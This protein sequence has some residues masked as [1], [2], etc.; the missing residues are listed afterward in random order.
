MTDTCQGLR[1]EL[2]S[3]KK[4]SKEQRLAWYFE[5]LKL[6]SRQQL[7]SREVRDALGLT[8]LDSREY[9]I[10]REK[11]VSMPSPEKRKRIVREAVKPLLKEAGFR[12]KGQEWWKEL[13]DGWL[14]IHLKSSQFNSPSTGCSFEFDISASSFEEIRGEL[15]KQWI[16]NQC[17]D[18][19]HCCFLPYAGMLS[20][21]CEA[22]AYKIDGYQNYLPKD[23]PLDAILEQVHSD[24]ADYILPQLEK[25]HSISQ[26]KNL[27]EE[28]QAY[29]QEREII[30]L[31]FYHNVCGGVSMG[32]KTSLMEWYQ[33][34]YSLTPE[35]VL[36]HLDWLETIC[37]YSSWP[38]E[39]R[40][41]EVRDI[42]QSLHTKGQE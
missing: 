27:Y 6:P 13:E 10:Q 33:K 9:Q 39:D 42:L 38:N 36:S 14:F 37:K 30:I 34:E 35:E 5:M 2:E 22:Y 4:E 23:D 41:S 3:R 15:N 31:K 19:S 40:V 7:D 28:R 8:E 25:V 32:S 26:W 12:T 11:E 17:C 18:L 29:L 1:Q 20:P 24:F 21:Y 16:Y